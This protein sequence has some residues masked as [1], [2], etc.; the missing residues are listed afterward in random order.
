MSLEHGLS[1]M[2]DLEQ[3]PDQVAQIVDRRE[4]MKRLAKKYATAGNFLFLGRGINYPVALEGALKL[5]EVSYVHAE[6]YSAAE[7]KHGPIALINDDTP[8]F[9]VVPDNGLRDKVISNMKEVKARRGPVLALAVEGDTEVERIA[10]D[11]FYV[12]KA[13]EYMYPFLMVVPFQLFAYYTALELG[14]NVDQPRNLAKS[15]TVE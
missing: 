4:D 5:K 9:F 1:F 12:P 14:R 15:V 7:I 8:S 3:V 6:G 13:H 11:V 10:D 2:R